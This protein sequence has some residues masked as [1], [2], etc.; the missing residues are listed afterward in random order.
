MEQHHNILDSILELIYDNQ[1][2]FS[3]VHIDDVLHEYTTLHAHM[4]SLP[5]I[6]C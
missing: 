2:V 4:Q 6:Q 1:Q 3:N 5:Y